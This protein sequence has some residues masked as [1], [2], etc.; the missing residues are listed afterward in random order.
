MNYKLTLAMP[1]FFYRGNSEIKPNLRR[2][3][4]TLEELEVLSDEIETIKS[5]L[6][7]FEPFTSLIKVTEE[8]KPE[9]FSQRGYFL[10]GEMDLNLLKKAVE[11]RLVDKRVKHPA[12]S[13]NPLS[14]ALASIAIS[15]NDT[16][17]LTEFGRNTKLILR[18]KV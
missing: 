16:H 8:D 5:D 12:F 15:Y 9:G 1:C 6:V 4:V 17:Y 3:L 14:P 13:D 11:R 7:G 10:C 2:S 18:E